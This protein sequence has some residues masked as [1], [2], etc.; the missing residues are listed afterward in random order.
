MNTA[1]MPMPMADFMVTRRPGRLLRLLVFPLASVNAVHAHPRSGEALLA[2]LDGALSAGFVDTANRL[3]YQELAAGDMFIFPKGTVRRQ[4]NWGART[5]TAR[6]AFRSAAPRRVS[7]PVTVFCTDIDDAMLAKPFKTDAPTTQ[8]TRSSRRYH[9]IDGDQRRAAHRAGERRSGARGPWPSLRCSQLV[10]SVSPHDSD[11][12][13]R[14][15]DESLA[16]EEIASRRVADAVPP[17]LADV[18]GC[19]KNTTSPG[20]RASAS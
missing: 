3:Y 10:M 5:A 20:L 11:S 2:V 7:V 4:F 12:T 15:H 16:S 6:S 17:P 1:T 8:K 14:H 9:G 18:S 13:A 19:N